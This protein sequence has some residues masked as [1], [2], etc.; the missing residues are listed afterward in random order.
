MMRTLAGWFL[1]LIGGCLCGALPAGAQEAAREALPLRDVVL[2]SSGVGYFQRA[3]QVNGGATVDLAFRAEQVNDILKSMVLFDPAGNVRPVNY[4]TK[5]PVSRQLRGVG[6][7]VRQDISLGALLQRFQGARVRLELAKGPAVEG[8]IVSVSTKTVPVKEGQAMEVEVISVHSEGGLRSIPLEQVLQARLL[9]ERLDRQLRES[10]E[11]LATGLDEQRRTVALRFAGGGAREV[12]VGYLQEMPV[13]KTSYRLVLGKTEKPYL[14]GWAIVENTT[15]EDW[16][17]VRLSLVSGRPVSFIQE[18]YQPLYVPRPVVQAQVIGSPTPQT[19]GEAL[20][21]DKSKGRP[22]A[23]G[24]DGVAKGEEKAAPAPAAPR[25]APD[26]R[27]A[28]P[29]DEARREGVSAEELARS[30]ASQAEGAERGDLFEYAI[31]QPVTLLRQQAAMLP[32]VSQSI[33]GEPLSIYDATSDAA[34]ALNGFRLKNSTGLHL[35]GGP[36]TVF[37]DG[38]YAGDAQVGHVQPGEERLLS[39]AVDLDLVVGRQDADPR[40]EILS[41]T[42]KG[43]VLLIT[44]KQQRE[45]VY[46]FRNKSEAPKTVLVQQ[47]IEPEFKLALPPSAAEQTPGEYRFLVSVPA[48]QT[49]ELKVVTERPLSE[50]VALLNADL[51]VVIAF[52]RHAQASPR[53]RAAL[54]Q[55]V[56]QRQKVLDLQGQRAGFEAELKGIDQEQTRIRQNMAQLD[57]NSPLYQQ[58]VKKLTEQETR[59]EKLQSEIQR[60]RDAEA[61]AQK[62]LR[63][64]VASLTAE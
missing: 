31:R 55:L 58:Y 15:E 56:E 34:H 57:R 26:A 52:G 25:K 19:Y 4:L 16:K 47:R 60:L 44:R 27:Y 51:S 17:E 21:A 54:G 53:I 7:A 13:W 28:A 11:L 35:S 14:Q 3:G 29:S 20:E 18:L 33:E 8:R 63:E 49:A 50:T 48:K 37:Q 5:D 2:F 9:D 1:M 62:Q 32:I 23:S 6:L 40:Q 45:R 42:A 64:F 12:R 38:G 24:E 41:I 22:P 61:A 59:I 46:T 30:L 36:V 10:L 39:Y 43:G